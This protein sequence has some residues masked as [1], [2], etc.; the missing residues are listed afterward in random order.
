MRVGWE[1]RRTGL[2]YWRRIADQKTGN[3]FAGWGFLE[4]AGMDAMDKSNASDSAAELE[5]CAPGG[6]GWRSRG[7]L[8]QWD[9][10]G[11]VPAFHPVGTGQRPAPFRH[12][13]IPTRS[14]TGRRSAS[15][16]G[17]WFAQLAES[18]AVQ[19][20]RAGLVAWGNT[21]FIANLADDQSRFTPTRAGRESQ[22]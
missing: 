4:I 17:G 20:A 6:V 14:C 5:L 11:L 2:V 1:N 16:G 18:F 15:C 22:I 13:P 10:V 8:P 7:D 9:E 3:G 21:S 19:S 12:V